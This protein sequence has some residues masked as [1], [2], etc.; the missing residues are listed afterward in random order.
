[1]HNRRLD[2]RYIFA[3]RRQP[4]LRTATKRFCGHPVHP[5]IGAVHGS[6]IGN[7]PLHGTAGKAI[8]ALI[9]AYTLIDSLLL[10]LPN[11]LPSRRTGQPRSTPDHFL[12]ASV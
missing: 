9:A 4:L 3:D 8:A 7:Y 2:K 10:A 11:Q 12:V 6:Q 1:M 5:A